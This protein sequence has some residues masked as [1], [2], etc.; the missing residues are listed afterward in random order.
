MGSVI[1]TTLLALVVDLRKL[2]LVVW[3][4]YSSYWKAPEN[5]L[6]EGATKRNQAGR[7]AILMLLKAKDPLLAGRGCPGLEEARENVP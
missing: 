7:S 1:D 2:E 3:V 6:E 4:K 5:R